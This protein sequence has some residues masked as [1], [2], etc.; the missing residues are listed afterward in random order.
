MAGSA[1]G[2]GNLWRFPYLVGENGGAA[3]II[4]YLAIIFT[5][6]LPILYS[7]FLIGRRG[8]RDVLGTFKVLAPNSKWKYTGII[9]FI[10]C[11]VILAFYNV[12][13][14]WTI[15]YLIKAISFDFHDPS[16]ADYDLLFDEFTASSI[17]PILYAIIFLLLTALVVD[18]G[19]K[20]GIEK[21][22]K[23]MMPLLF[24]IVIVIAVRSITLPD[25]KE[26]L[27]YLFKPD[28]SKVTADTFIA[29]LGQAFFS[30]SVGSASILTYASFVKK[31]EQIISCSALTALSDT[32]FAII[33]GCAIMPA[34]FAFGISPQE[35]P[36][37]VFVTLPGIFAQLP[38]GGVIAIFFFLALLIAALTSSISLLNALVEALI[39]QFHFSKRKAMIICVLALVVVNSLCSLS[40]G[41]LSDVKIFGLNFF[42]AFDGLSSNILLPI[43]GLSMV[44]FAGW[45]LGKVIVYDELT[46]QGTLKIP[47]WLLEWTFFVMRFLAP[48][49]ITVV[50]VS[51]FLN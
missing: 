6:C 8:Q 17:K 42:D 47:K 19:I 7:E 27:N 30:L 4:I 32:T 45:K 16:I 21:F 25:A 3:F 18:G 13:G 46:N 39:E 24:V 51:Q 26:G 20:K 29:A 33:S 40:L 49:I 36:G 12:V 41:V 48:V 5:I 43:A 44:L 23:V 1:V 28:F 11:F 50:M 31:D 34:V 9:S 38:F 2:L 35:G 15:E 10:S 14:G 22:S 37:L